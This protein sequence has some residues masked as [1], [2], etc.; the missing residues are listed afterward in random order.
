MTRH[1]EVTRLRH[2]LDH[3]TEAIEMAERRQREDLDN[4]RKLNLSLVRLAEIVGEAATH[5][6]QTTQNELAGVP[7]PQIVGL[8]NRLIHG[9]DQVDFDV[10]WKI[11]QVDLPPLVVEL[12]KA[13]ADKN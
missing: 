12:R 10:L 7:W 4:D 6:S 1:D 9:Y 8:R 3:A 2:M 5:V 11:I 13:I